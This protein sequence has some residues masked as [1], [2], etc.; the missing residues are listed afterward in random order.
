MKTNGIIVAGVLGVCALI[1]FGTS[2][3]VSP[4]LESINLSSAEPE[5]E[6]YVE[7]RSELAADYPNAVI[8]DDD[9]ESLACSVHLVVI[10]DCYEGPTDTPT[11]YGS[12]DIEIDG[13][14]VTAQLA[15]MP[16]GAFLLQ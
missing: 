4:V 5:Q 1:G 13:K 14:T 8:T 9:L 16:G 11:R 7:L 2:Q 3:L 12:A 6:S 10:K 15:A